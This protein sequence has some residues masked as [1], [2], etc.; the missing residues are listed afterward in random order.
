VLD[1]F[2]FLSGGLVELF[3]GTGELVYLKQATALAKQAMARFACPGG[4]WFLTSGAEQEPLGRR[5]EVSDGVEPSGNAAMLLVLE[6]L[7]ALSGTDD[8]IKPVNHALGSYAD[9]IRQQGVDMAGWLDASLLSEGPFYEVVIAGKDG[10][11]ARAWNGLSPA[12]TVG[13]QI[14]SDGP[15]AAQESVLPIAAGKRDRN[16]VTLAYVCVHGSCKQPTTEPA[17]LRRE[18]LAGWIR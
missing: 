8:F 17:R 13:V 9:M 10:A 14:G 1:D 12:W 11:L 2:A 15:T 6:K 4:G 18:L 5:L 3:E 16:G 7:T